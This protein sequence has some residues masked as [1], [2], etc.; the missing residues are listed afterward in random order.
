MNITWIDTETP[1]EFLDKL[2]KHQF[3]ENAGLS[4]EQQ[5]QALILLRYNNITK[6]KLYLSSLFPHMDK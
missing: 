2:V 1:R 4:R 3:G 6:L 5:D